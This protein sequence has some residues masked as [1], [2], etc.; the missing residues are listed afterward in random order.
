MGLRGLLIPLVLGALPL[1][2]AAAAPKPNCVFILVDDLGHNDVGYNNRTAA[3]VVAGRG[4][5]SPNI[6]H[7]AD[8]G[9]KLLNYYVQPI[10]TP[11]RS[12]LITG[13]YAFRW[14]ATAYTIVSEEP[15]GVPL[16]ETFVSSLLQAEGY[17]TAVFGKWHMGL[18]KDEY[19]PHRRGFNL[20]TGML[21][22]ASDHYTH[23]VEG[24][25][26]WHALTANGVEMLPNFA[27]DGRYAGKVSVRDYKAHLS[28]CFSMGGTGCATDVSTT[29]AS[30]CATTP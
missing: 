6:D 7:L 11:T 15:W 9:L 5:V 4:I 16:A 22:G 1:A 28:P 24:A 29:S 20:S 19:L 30:W 12:A 14:G 3:G 25:Y 17:T 23:Q 10:C 27:A 21:S 13:R 2:A 26:D 18:F 8:S